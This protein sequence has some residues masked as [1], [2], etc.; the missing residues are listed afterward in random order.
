[1]NYRILWQCEGRPMRASTLV[2]PSEEEA[3]KAIAALDQAY[4]HRYKHY[5]LKT[6]D[7]ATHASLDDFKEN[8]S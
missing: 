3:L 6:E 8:P 2:L 7:A 5:A 4:G 1:M